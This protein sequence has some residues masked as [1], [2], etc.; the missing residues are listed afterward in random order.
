MTKNSKNKDS[1][2]SIASLHGL[3]GFAAILVFWY[4]ARWKAG[5]PE[6]SIFGFDFRRFLQ[7]CDIGVC[8]FFVLSGFLLT[9]KYCD[10]VFDSGS[11]KPRPD[12]PKYFSRRLARILPLYFIV[13]FVFCAFDRFTY[14]AYGL[15]DVFLHV[16]CLHTFCSFSYTS[17]NPVLWTIGIEVQFYLLLPL[18]M[19]AMKYLHQK[20]GWVAGMAILLATFFVIQAGFHQLQLFSAGFV[21]DK[22]LD[23]NGAMPQTIFYYL[24]WFWVGIGLAFVRYHW[25]HLAVTG[26]ALELSFLLSAG[27]FVL[28]I[29]FSTEGGWRSVSFWGWPLNCIVVAA[30]IATSSTSQV[31]RFLFDNQ[32][33][34]FLG[35]LSY[36]V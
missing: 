19:V 14:N 8:L 17:I 2:V 4:H 25:S 21:P 36:G 26:M 1:N 10:W 13:V 15:L 16:S 31:G 32:F 12:T 35:E 6:L 24:P 22:I 5:D 20:L 7:H 23:S 27:A 18:L 11:S 34:R 3:R 30:L 33:M 29:V 28:L 9:L